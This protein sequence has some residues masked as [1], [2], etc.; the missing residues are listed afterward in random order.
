MKLQHAIAL[1]S[2]GW[3]LMVPPTACDVSS[4]CSNKSLFWGLVEAPFR[5][6]ASRQWLYAWRYRMKIKIASDAPLREWQQIGEFE[7]LSDCRQRYENNLKETPLDKQDVVDAAQAELKDEGT[8]TPSNEELKTRVD[9]IESSIH[10]RALQGKCIA[11]DDPR[12]AR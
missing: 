8:S 1:A 12:L 3:Y 5:G 2:I 7:T 9:S 11:T 10:N 6:E 4:A